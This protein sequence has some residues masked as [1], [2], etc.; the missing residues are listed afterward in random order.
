M[1]FI[2]IDNNTSLIKGSTENLS[3]K[4]GECYGKCK[5]G[6]VLILILLILIL[7]IIKIIENTSPIQ[8]TSSLNQ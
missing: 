6:F 4:Y 1:S 7:L 8:K 3:T 5:I 2:T